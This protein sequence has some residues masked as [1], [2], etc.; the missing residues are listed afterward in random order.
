MTPGT[1]RLHARLVALALLAGAAACTNSAGD[2]SSPEDVRSAYVLMGPGG[3]AIARAITVAPTCPAISLDGAAHRLLV[4]V[5]GPDVVP[6][7]NL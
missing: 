6:G 1:A 2:V 5:G 3:E 4:R 7:H